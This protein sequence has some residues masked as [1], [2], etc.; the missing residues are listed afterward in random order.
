MSCFMCVNPSGLAATETMT[1]VRLLF[2]PQQ[3][4]AQETQ[5]RCLIHED[6][7]EISTVGIPDRRY[8]FEIFITPEAQR[9]FRFPDSV[10]N[11]TFAAILDAAR[12]QRHYWNCTNLIAPVQIVEWTVRPSFQP[13]KAAKPEN[14]TRGA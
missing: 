10:N 13:Y 8:K 1:A 14:L 6:K 12:S 4:A 5:C 2:L 7:N 11:A 3:R 9:S